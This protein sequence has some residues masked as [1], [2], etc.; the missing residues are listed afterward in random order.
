MSLA[1]YQGATFIHKSCVVAMGDF[2]HFVVVKFKDGV[3]VE[4]LIQG[5]EK[6]VSGIQQVK[7]FEWGKD[8]ESHDM[9]RQ[10]FTHVFLMTFNGKEEF[11]TFQTH[12]NHIEFSGV[13]S[14]SI[15]K[16]VVLDFPSK[17]VKAPA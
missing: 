3:A 14:P 12:P 1:H 4:E 17:L 8:I 5:L 11:N 6:M 9:L 7:S 16:I 13:F 15:E 10:G 2:N